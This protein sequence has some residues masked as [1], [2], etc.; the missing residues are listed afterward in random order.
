MPRLDKEEIKKAL[1]SAPVK[2]RRSGRKYVPKFSDPRSNDVL[3]DG[4]PVQIQDDG[5]VVELDASTNP[6]VRKTAAQIQHKEN[7][8]L[9]TDGDLLDI[10][11][12]RILNPDGITAPP[13]RIKTPG[14]RIRWINLS[15]SGRYQRAR[16]E[17]GWQPVLKTQLID[18]R[19]I[20]GVSYTS[21]GYVCRG[22]KQQEMLMQMP[23][24]VYKKIQKRR[25]DLN[26][27]S[28]ET[29][30]EQMASAGSTHFTDKYGSTAGQ[31]A[32]EAAGSFKGDIKF[33]TESVSSEEM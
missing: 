20:Y 13:I 7:A 19:E 30:R 1:T 11:D 33:G 2:P 25:I 18:A 31:Q 27:K 16:Y 24:A 9:T 6:P 5:S 8:S 22:E 21:E 3:D 32:A 26:R 23:E 12:R 14:M 15:Q 28:Y 17:Q 4:V 29:L 10:W